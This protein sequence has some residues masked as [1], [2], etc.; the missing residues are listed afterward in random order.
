MSYLARIVLVCSGLDTLGFRFQWHGKQKAEKLR[1]ERGFL[2][3][4]GSYGPA[5]IALGFKIGKPP[6]DLPPPILA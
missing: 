5:A 2:G 6:S 1:D 4:T 3:L